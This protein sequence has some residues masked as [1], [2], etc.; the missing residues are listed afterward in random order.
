M[1]GLMGSIVQAAA[2][3]AAQVAMTFFVPFCTT[4]LAMLA[5]I[6]VTNPVLYCTVLYCAVLYCGGRARPSPCLRASR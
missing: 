2:Q 4:A 3:L 1:R 6:Q 5:R